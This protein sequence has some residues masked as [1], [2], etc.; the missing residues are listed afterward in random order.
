L[1]RNT[2]MRDECILFQ[3][4][5][6]EDS[7]GY[8]YISISLSPTFSLFVSETVP[9]CVFTCQLFLFEKTSYMPGYNTTV[10]PGTY[11]QRQT[12]PHSKWFNHIPIRPLVLRLEPLSCGTGR[13]CFSCKETCNPPS[14]KITMLKLDIL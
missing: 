8:N 11:K 9:M 12:L 7:L 2:D 5:K 6:G 10:A 1:S 14:T 13:T 3:P 4:H